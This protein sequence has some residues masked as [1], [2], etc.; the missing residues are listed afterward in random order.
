MKT[1]DK[2]ARLR[3]TSI[4]VVILAIVML[5]FPGVDGD[6]DITDKLVAVAMGIDYDGGALTVTVNSVLPVSGG[7]SGSVTSVPVSQSGKSVAECLACVMDEMAD[8]QAVGQA[9]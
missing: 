5:M 9:Q 7:E 8:A 4:A 3:F 1:S 2:N 6:G